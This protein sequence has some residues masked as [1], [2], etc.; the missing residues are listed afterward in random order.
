[1]DA[2]RQEAKNRQQTRERI[3]IDRGVHRDTYMFKK[4]CVVHPTFTIAAIGGK[5]IAKIV[6]KLKQNGG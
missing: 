3:E 6:S 4:K 5:M 1:M 2:S